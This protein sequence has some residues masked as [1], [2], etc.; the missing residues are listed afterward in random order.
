MRKNFVIFVDGS[1]FREMRCS[2]LIVLIIVITTLS[3]CH[4]VSELTQKAELT[5]LEQ[6]FRTSTAIGYCA[7]LADIAFSGGTLPP[8]VSLNLSGQPGYTSSGVIHVHVD[9]STPLPF[10]HS[11]GDI[12]I[13]GLW[14]GINGGGFLFVFGGFYFFLFTIKFFCI[15]SL[16][17]I[18]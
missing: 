8:N 6:G 7:S 3:G 15:F 16:F 1:E 13:A 5:P 4:K 18:K 17:V 2:L 9:N 10:S 14:D 11:A 12:Y